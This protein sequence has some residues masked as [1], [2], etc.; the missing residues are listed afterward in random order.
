MR[1]EMW[2]R[3]RLYTDTT[4]NFDGIKKAA[5]EEY[6]ISQITI[7]NEDSGSVAMGYNKKIGAYEILMDG[8]D[9]NTAYY[10]NPQKHFK[11]YISAENK[12]DDR[13]IYIKTISYTGA[14]ESLSLI[15]I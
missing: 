1:K 6:K 15:H 11:A 7:Y 12:Y 14:L 9:F 8:T 4:D 2:I 3:D 10:D 13:N 5:G